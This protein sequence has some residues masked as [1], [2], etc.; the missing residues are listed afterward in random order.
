M[1]LKCVW[2]SAQTIVITPGS[3]WI[4][5]H[6]PLKM[7]SLHLPPT[8]IPSMWD[9][10]VAIVATC[11]LHSPQ[12]EFLHFTT[13][14]QLCIGC[15]C[16]D[17]ILCDLMENAALHRLNHAYPKEISHQC[18]TVTHT[19]ALHCKGVLLRAVSDHWR[20]LV[21]PCGCQASHQTPDASTPC[22]VADE[23]VL[24]TSRSIQGLVLLIWLFISCLMI[25]YQFTG[26]CFTMDY[27]M[28]WYPSQLTCEP[29]F[30]LY[31]IILIDSPS[32]TIAWDL[33]FTLNP[34]ADMALSCRIASS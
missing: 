25:S 1:W 4:L 10:I 24:E 22:L 2:L 28:L 3:C 19:E 33:F 34:H 8:D 6:S 30:V 31:W 12:V 32:W 21:A 26:G 29:C 27:M 13:C 5:I 17:I 18:T 11:R 20:L 23:L 14:A 7:Q 15:C 9:Y 16:M